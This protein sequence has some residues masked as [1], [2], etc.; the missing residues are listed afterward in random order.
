IDG[1]IVCDAPPPEFL[2]WAIDNAPELSTPG[3]RLLHRVG[4]RPVPGVKAA[5][6]ALRDRGLMPRGRGVGDL[7]RDIAE[8][9][10]PPRPAALD[11]DRVW[12]EIPRGPTILR[13]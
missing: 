3:A 8:L 6:A 11:L 13:G 4:L 9:D 7:T 2:A 1:S 10:Q 5:R 12:H